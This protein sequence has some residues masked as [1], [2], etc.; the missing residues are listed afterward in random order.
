ML[1]IGLAGMCS[2]FCQALLPI[3]FSTYWA[4]SRGDLSSQEQGNLN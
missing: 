4:I 3:E 1:L 2:G